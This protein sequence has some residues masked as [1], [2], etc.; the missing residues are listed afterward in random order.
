MGALLG[1]K[2]PSLLAKSR[3]IA[4]VSGWAGFTYMIPDYHWLD[5]HTLMFSRQDRDHAFTFFTF[6][7][8]DRGE[9][10]SG[11]TDQFRKFSGGLD[12]VSISPNGQKILW[13][14][15]IGQV[16]NWFVADLNG[17][18]VQIVPRHKTSEIISNHGP[19]DETIA[20]WSRNS[21][22]IFESIIEFGKGTSTLLWGRSLSSI[23]KERTY[24][25]A[26]G[27][28]DWQPDMIGD[29]VAFA[30][31]GLAIGAERSTAGFIT[32][33]IENPGKTRKEWTVR[34]PKGRNI[35]SFS[36]SPKGDL[37][38]W[39]LTVKLTK[40]PQVWDSKGHDFWLTDVRGRNWRRVASIAYDL[41]TWVKQD[42]SLSR[43][44][45]RPD[46]KAFTFVYDQ[47]LFQFSLK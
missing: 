38:L 6:D 42:Q 23:D 45:W 27:Y 39:D 37:I 7:L 1:Q 17:Q 14:G 11:F 22:S 30:H 36:F 44:Q 40:D 13:S 47:K 8:N 41:K 32:W 12:S 9:K 19:D 5:S 2:S 34:V 33:N 28:V 20:F 21:K 29:K 25:S 18:N 3:L 31:S 15:R 26:K 43:P 46:G 16:N 10:R 35:S 24:P 4:D